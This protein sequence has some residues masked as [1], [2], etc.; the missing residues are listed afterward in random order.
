MGISMGHKK[1]IKIDQK[2]TNKYTYNFSQTKSSSISA[3]LCSVFEDFHGKENIFVRCP[4]L[5]T[6]DV[7]DC[8]EK[9]FSDSAL[10][11][12]AIS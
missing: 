1:E 2:Q 4:R 7:V 12:K 10:S 6:I 9:F 5:M 3:K 11:Q 8:Q